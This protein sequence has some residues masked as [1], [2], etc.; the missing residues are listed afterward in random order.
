MIFSEKK[1]KKSSIVWALLVAIYA[2][3][4]LAQDLPKQEYTEQIQTFELK[5]GESAT[6]TWPLLSGESV[7]S[8]ASL[9][10]PKNTGMQRLFIKTTLDYNREIYPNLNAYTT[11]N[12]SSVIV[13]PTLKYLAL[14]SGRISIQSTKFV[15]H[16]KPLIQ[17]DIEPALQIQFSQKPA[18]QFILMSETQKAYE[19][20]VIRNE[21]LKKGLAKLDAKLAH[22]QEEMASLS[23]KAKYIV[24]SQLAPPSS[25][26][27]P[28]IT[29]AVVATAPLAGGIE[30]AKTKSQDSKVGVSTD[31]HKKVN[32]TLAPIED[33]ESLVSHFG[34]QIPLALFAFGSIFATY[35][36]RRRQSLNFL[37]D[38]FE[39]NKSSGSTIGHTQ[40]DEPPT[41]KD[42]SLSK[43]EFSGSITDNDLEAIMSIKHKEAGDLVLEQARIY[44]SV[45]RHEEAILILKEQIHVAPNF[46]LNHCL[47]LLEIYRQTNQKEQFLE[48]AQQLHHLFNVV[49]PTWDN[50]P[51]VSI[52]ASSLLEFPHITGPLTKLWGEC[53]NSLE[54]LIE[55]KGFLDNLLLDNRDSERSGFGLEVLLEIRLLRNILDIRDQFYYQDKP[56]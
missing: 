15:R 43:S 12:Q 35:R 52:V 56:S 11:L 30:L 8:L 45:D 54:K 46:S 10:Y 9:F 3:F 42:F 37:A 6:I 24:S 16:N 49:Q 47:A 25:K 1:F 13:I 51:L 40:E 38:K 20:L 32:A 53:E 55:A 39:P 34:L 44:V 33:Q 21:Q 31:D 50:I 4:S 18:N 26:L 41:T 17:Q 23:L 2:S 48:A 7:Q 22:L 36:Y 19:G 28:E 14:H 27:L 5:G 29:T